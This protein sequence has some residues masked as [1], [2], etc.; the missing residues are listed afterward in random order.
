[1]DKQERGTRNLAKL[2]TV[3]G[4]VRL[5]VWNPTPDDQ[6]TTT[7]HYTDANLL[8]KLHDTLSEKHQ[9]MFR[10]NLATLSGLH[11]MATFAW[12]HAEF[13]QA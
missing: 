10:S 13:R 5:T 11:K 3:K 12:K 7:V 1:V 2:R 9:A 4:R 8:A 6:T